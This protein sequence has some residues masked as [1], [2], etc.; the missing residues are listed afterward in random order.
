MKTLSELLKTPHTDACLQYLGHIPLDKSQK[1][2]FSLAQKTNFWSLTVRLYEKWRFRSTALLSK[3]KLDFEQECA[4]MQEWIDLQPNQTILDVGSSTGLYARKL[5]HYADNKN[6]PVQIIGTDISPKFV[7]FANHQIKRENLQQ[8]RVYVTD[9]TKLPFKNELF[10]R[11]I[12]G[13]SFNEISHYE[14]A[15]QEW[16]RVLKHN[17]KLFSMNLIYAKKKNILM[18][19]LSLSGIHIHT[20]DEMKMLFEKAGFI[21]LQSKIYHHLALALYQKV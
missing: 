11:I 13:G 7:R 9:T 20:A 15:I 3:K 6:I 12:I 21:Q 14:L 18:R 2:S 10:D 16:Y 19:C 4:I 1:N 8:V 5:K 17:G